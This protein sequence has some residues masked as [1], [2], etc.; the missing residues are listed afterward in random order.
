M[1]YSPFSWSKSVLAASFFLLVSGSVW[2]QKTSVTE[3][4]MNEDTTISIKK[5]S[6]A[7]KCEKMY[8]IV[9]GTG[10]VEGDPNVLVKEARASWKQ[11]CNQWKKE[12]R[13]MNQDSKV[14]AI[15]C[16]KSNC[17]QQ[18]SEGQ[19]CHSEGTYKIKTKVN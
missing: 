19:V 9:E 6:S 13:D 17:T 3:I 7:S 4:P 16:G 8:E 14:I 2:A 15:D 10:Q 11:A 1:S 18:G 12:V 5:G